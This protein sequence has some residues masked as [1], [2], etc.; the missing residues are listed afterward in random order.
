MENTAVSNPVILFCLS[1]L[2]F[3]G[4]LGKQSLVQGLHPCIQGPVSWGH[5]VPGESTPQ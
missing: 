1:N 3:S 5:K 2:G 4:L